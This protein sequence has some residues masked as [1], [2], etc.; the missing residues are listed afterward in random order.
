[1]NRTAFASL[2]LLA[3]GLAACADAAPDAATIAAATARAEAAA[4]SL[5]SALVGELTKALQEGD[6]AAAVDVCGEVAQSITM[7]NGGEDG[8]RVARTALRVRNPVNAPA[9]YERAVLERWSD[10][11]E[12][13]DWSEVVA[14]DGGHEL[15]WMRP[16]RL[17]PMCTQCH[18]NSDEILPA[19]RAAI[20]ARYPD[21]QAI[22]FAPGDLRGAVTVR[23]PLAVSR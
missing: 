22:D 11:A 19:T 14:T 4:Q 17:L 20:R 2:C 7:R 15:R 16:I 6:A 1:M 10:A 23:A 3:S 8:F 9:P 21:D 12:A 13:Q 5:T 18:G